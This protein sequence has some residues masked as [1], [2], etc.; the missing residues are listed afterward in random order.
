MNPLPIAVL[1]LISQGQG[2][3]NGRGRRGRG[4]GGLLSAGA[5]FDVAP[6]LDGLY[7][8]ANA[9]ERIDKMAMQPDWGKQQDMEIRTFRRR[10]HF[11]REDNM[12]CTMTETHM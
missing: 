10:V 8:T 4:A 12:I 1:L 2:G 11:H 6:V 3:I 7:R 5:D 9:L